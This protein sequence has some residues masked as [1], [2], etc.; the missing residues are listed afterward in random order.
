MRTSPQREG[1]APAD[2]VGS[3]RP[4]DRLKRRRFLL[5]LG[6]GSAASAAAAAR[7]RSQRPMVPTRA[8][9]AERE[10]LRLRETDHVRTYY[11]S[12]RI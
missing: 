4:E 3:S 11:A 7:R 12:T 6:A 9:A 10:V 5:A 2:S 1:H 8:A